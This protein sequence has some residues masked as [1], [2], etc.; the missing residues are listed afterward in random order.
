MLKG[1]GAD[2]APPK[3]RAANFERPPGAGAD[4]GARPS[5]G[6]PHGGRMDLSKATPEQLERVKKR[7]RE[8]GMTDEQIE[9]AL[10]RRGQ[11]R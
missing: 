10:A 2:E 5:M 7:M 3:A 6:G 8:R 1:P 11:Q 9:Q 4:N